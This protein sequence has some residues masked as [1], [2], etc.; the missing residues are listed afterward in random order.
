MDADWTDDGDRTGRPLIGP[1]GH[2]SPLPLGR[3]CERPRAPCHS[4]PPPP[5]C[6]SERVQRAKNL[7]AL[8]LKGILPYGALFILGGAGVSPAYAC[9]KA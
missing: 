9:L 5:F 7:A 3:R 2:D 8:A 6:H 4:D 1:S